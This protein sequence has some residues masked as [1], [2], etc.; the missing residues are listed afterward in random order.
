MDWEMGVV[1]EG[2]NGVVC[3]TIGGPRPTDEK[4]ELIATLY[5]GS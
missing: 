4:L 1:G 2:A 5:G 3:C